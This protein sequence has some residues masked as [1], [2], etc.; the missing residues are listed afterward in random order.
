[1]GRALLVVLLVV[2]RAGGVLAQA[3]ALAAGVQPYVAVSDPVVALTHV[4][5]IDGTGAAPVADQTIVISSGKIQAVGP[6]STVRAPT[7][8]RTIDLTGHT[9]IP[10]LVG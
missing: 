6:A 8:A 9:V 1:M 3:P 10:G 5:V 4:R 2:V 7:G